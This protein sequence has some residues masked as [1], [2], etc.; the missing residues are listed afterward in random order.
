MILHG[1]PRAGNFHALRATFLRV[2]EARPAKISRAS[3]GIMTS[4]AC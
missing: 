2:A 3:R 1:A 4:I